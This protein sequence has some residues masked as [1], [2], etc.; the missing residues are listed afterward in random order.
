MN[1][2]HKRKYRNAYEFLVD[3]INS[4]L[5]ELELESYYD[6]GIYKKSKKAFLNFIEQ[7]LNECK[8]YLINT[9]YISFDLFI[10]LSPAKNS[11]YLSLLSKDGNTK[12]SVHF[13]NNKIFRCFLSNKNIKIGW[14]VDI[15]EI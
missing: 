11:I 15:L 3:R 4:R 13:Y 14:E 10:S 6:G 2:M 8:D 7:Q 12:F 9:S 5:H 1:Q